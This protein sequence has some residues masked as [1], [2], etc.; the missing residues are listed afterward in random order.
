MKS[1]IIAGALAL[2]SA[3]A[4]AHAGDMKGMDMKDDMKG[5]D[6]KS[7][8]KP[9]KG[10]HKAVGVVKKVDTKAATVTIAHEPVK[11]M[12][13]P[14]M[15]MTFHVK[16]KSMLDKLGEGKKVEVEFEQRGKDYVITSAK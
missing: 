5:M 8:S 12:N 9:A 4:L 11:S 13:W 15:N 2:A 1:L 16:D 6:M 7:S 3:A 14:A 10:L